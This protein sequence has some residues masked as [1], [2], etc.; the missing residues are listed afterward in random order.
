M[1]ADAV[2]D[3]LVGAELLDLGAQGPHCVEGRLGVG[4]AAEPTDVRLAVRNRAEQERAV[5]D[6]F[7]AGNG[8][9]SLQRDCGLDPHAPLSPRTGETTTPYP[10]PSSSSAARAA[11][12]SPVTSTDSVPPRSGDM[13]PSSKSSM[14]MRSAPSAWVMPASTPGRSGTC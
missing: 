4:R 14:L 12:A 13:C 2:H 9:G 11:S 7:V 6:G 8:E 1:Q 10:W 3:Q 5:R